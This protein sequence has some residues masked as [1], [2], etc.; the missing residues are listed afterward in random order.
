MDDHLREDEQAANSRHGYGRKTVAA[1]SDDRTHLFRS[2]A[3]PRSD[4]IPR[5]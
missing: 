3:A 1:D 5:R 2:D 4:L